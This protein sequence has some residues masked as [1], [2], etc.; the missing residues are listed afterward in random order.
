MFC[1][2]MRQWQN[3]R[4]KRICY[5]VQMARA[6]TEITRRYGTALLPSIIIELIECGNAACYCGILH[7][8]TWLYHLYEFRFLS[9]ILQCVLRQVHSLLRQVHSPFQIQFSIECDLVRP[10]SFYSIIS[11]LKGHAIADYIF[12]LV[13][14]SLQSFPLSFLQ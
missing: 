12:F 14:P 3:L 5:W 6:A 1:E 4:Q 11:F 10:F 7:T 8:S 2:W 13:F 9:F